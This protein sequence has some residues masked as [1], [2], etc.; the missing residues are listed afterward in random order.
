M[1]FGLI[2]NSTLFPTNSKYKQNRYTPLLHYEIVK[3]LY[4]ENWIPSRDSQNLEGF[5]N[6][7][8]IELPTMIQTPLLVKKL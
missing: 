8:K 4:K 1:L 3:T 2:T 5:S 7:L 6:L